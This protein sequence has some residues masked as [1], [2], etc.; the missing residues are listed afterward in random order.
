MAFAA[1]DT[2]TTRL[3]A[4]ALSAAWLNDLLADC[5][6]DSRVLVLDC[7][8][9]GAHGR[10]KAGA[11]SVAAQLGEVG[12]GHAVLTASR[13]WEFSFEG[14]PSGGSVFTAGLVEGL[15]TGDADLDGDG[16]ITVEEAHIYA[17]G[18]VRDQGAQQ[19]PQ[20]W[21]TAAEGELILAHSPRGPRLARGPAVMYPPGHPRS[22]SWRSSSGGGLDIASG[23]TK[24]ATGA[25]SS[26]IQAAGGMPGPMG[27]TR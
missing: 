4:T 10:T 6:A 27:Q 8:F 12:S 23:I 24:A 2:G 26:A 19:H 17:A 9:S 15:R 18:Y 21:L 16:V 14:D 1:T 20:R 7:C 13:D 22:A 3:S 5:T 11:D 25:S